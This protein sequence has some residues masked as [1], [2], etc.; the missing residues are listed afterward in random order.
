MWDNDGTEYYYDK[1]EWVRIRVEQ[2]EW[3][4]VLPVPPSERERALANDRQC[5]YSITA[6]MRESGM[7]LVIWW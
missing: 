6:S 1:H 4:D 3:Q 2:E 5:P 7:G